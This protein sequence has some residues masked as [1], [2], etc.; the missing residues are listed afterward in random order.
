[1][2]KSETTAADYLARYRASFAD[3]TMV[4]H[5]A[6]PAIIYQLRKPGHGGMDGVDLILLGGEHVGQRIVV[7]GDLSPNDNQGCQS[8]LGYGLDWFAGRCSDHYLC[9]KFFR[10]VWVP[11]LARAE[12][13]ERLV[14]EQQEAADDEGN[15]AK[16][17]AEL[18]ERVEKL[19]EAVEH[20]EEDGDSIDDPTRSAEA[21]HDLWVDVY[22]DG[23][24]GMGYGY[25][26]RSAALLV[27][28]QETFSRLYWAAREVEKQDPPAAQVPA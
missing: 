22:H 8:N 4:K 7:T 10:K 9:E 21:F 23:P 11:D 28:I 24:E 18:R 25:D 26:P 12:L 13:R 19:E 2:S 27:A 16:A 6:E 15:N 17:R 5:G 3:Y 1:M 20:V 14:E